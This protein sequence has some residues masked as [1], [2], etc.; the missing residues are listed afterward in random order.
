[1]ENN[2][3]ELLF[4]S[5]VAEHCT[6]AYT[7][8]I[9]ITNTS[10]CDFY[11]Y[12]FWCQLGASFASSPCLSLLYG[13][14]RGTKIRW[15]HCEHYMIIFAARISPAPP[16]VLT[17]IGISLANQ[18]D[19]WHT[20]DSLSFSR[21]WPAYFR[22]NQKAPTTHLFDYLTCPSK[23]SL[24]CRIMTFCKE[25]S[26]ILKSSECFWESFQQAKQCCLANELSS[27]LKILLCMSVKITPR[28]TKQGGCMLL[29]GGS[30]PRLLSHY[31]SASSTLPSPRTFIKNGTW[32]MQFARLCP[33]PTTDSNI[34][35]YSCLEEGKKPASLP[36]AFTGG[37]AKTHKLLLKILRKFMAPCTFTSSTP[38]ASTF[39]DFP[40]NENHYRE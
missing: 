33:F 4:L 40:Q 21:N 36:L 39:S 25:E 5:G 17:A 8:S 3:N 31:P 11:A 6:H 37:S 26:A 30:Q 35:S 38:H 24:P 1:M 12:A 13:L 18:N 10:I 28:H 27:V 34:A 9:H 2:P 15:P 7:S 14:H 32:I 29:V 22:N 20:S 16:A 19:F 23:Q